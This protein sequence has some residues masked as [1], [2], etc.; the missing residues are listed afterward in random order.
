M[1][2]TEQETQEWLQ[3]RDTWQEAI[4]KEIHKQNTKTKDSSLQ[5]T[6]ADAPWLHTPWTV[7]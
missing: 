6:N 5:A 1:Q 2:N 4:Y 3:I 7:S